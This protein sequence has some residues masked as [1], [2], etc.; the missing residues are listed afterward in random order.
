MPRRGNRNFTRPE[1]IRPMVFSACSFEEFVR[2]L[3]ISPEQYKRSAR[4]REWV[5]QNKDHKY[6][7]T[8]LLES[9][10]FHG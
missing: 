4:L 7:P 9:F 5:R 3:K 2:R 8:D 1:A 6:V 10:G